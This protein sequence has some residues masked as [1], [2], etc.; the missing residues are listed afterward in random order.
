VN[1]AVLAITARPDLLDRRGQPGRAVG[2]DQA[3]RGES[4]GSEVTAELK[5]VLLVSR[6]PNRTKTSALAPVSVI[7]QAQITPSFGP[8]GQTGR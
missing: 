5:P 6:I 4:A 8:L 1:G 3:W 2:D 7:P